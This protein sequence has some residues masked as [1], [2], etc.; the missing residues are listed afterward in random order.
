[1]RKTEGGQHIPTKN[2]QLCQSAYRSP[3]YKNM[4]IV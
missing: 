3:K 1:M 2:Q 4:L